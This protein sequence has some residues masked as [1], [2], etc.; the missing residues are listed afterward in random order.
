MGNLAR[1]EGPR[2]GVEILGR[3]SKPPFPYVSGGRPYKL[4]SL[5]RGGALPTNGLRI[6]FTVVLCLSVSLVDCIHT[7]KDIVKLL[8]RPGSPIILVV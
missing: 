5:V 7:A 8:S 6:F 3:C 1:P 4:L 2:E